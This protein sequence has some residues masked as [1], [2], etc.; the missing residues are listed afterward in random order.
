MN[1]FNDLKFIFFNIFN[2]KDK[3]E[4][5][6]IRVFQWRRYFAWKDLTTQEKI[7][8]KRF[9]LLPVFAYIIIGIFNQNFSLIVLLLIG[10][11]LYKRFEKGNIIKK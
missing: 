6:L 3:T 5:K 9:L 10:Y 8:A 1:N 4:R 11:I 2:K 7:Q